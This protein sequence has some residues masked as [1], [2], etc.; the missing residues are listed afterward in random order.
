VIRDKEIWYPDNVRKFLK[1]SYSIFKKHNDAFS[2]L[3][4]T[5]LIKTED[6]RVLVNGMRGKLIL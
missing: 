4:P 6:N 1:K 3:E 2:S 5:P